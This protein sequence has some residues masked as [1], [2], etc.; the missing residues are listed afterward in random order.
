MSFNSRGYD[1]EMVA[2]LQECLEQAFAASREHGE[3]DGLRQKLASAVMEGANVGIRDKDRLVEFALRAL[4]A[5]RERA[6][7]W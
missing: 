4:P 1:P 3:V 2:L 6:L 5:F 7:A